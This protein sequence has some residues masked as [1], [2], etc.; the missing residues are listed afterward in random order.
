MITIGQISLTAI[1]LALIGAFVNHRLAIARDT[2]NKR[3]DQAEKTIAAFRPELEAL[4]NTNNDARIILTPDAFCR[5][6][7]AI[8]DFLPYLSYFSRFKMS[9]AWGKLVYYENK[10]KSKTPFYAQYAD[11]GSLNIRNKMRPL[12]IERIQ[13]I[14]S[15][16][17]E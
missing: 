7:A 17:R 3:S 12:A 9:R 16:C 13:R 14:I 11:C 15:L 6:E 1:L 2:R 8:N 5:H 10:E 4:I